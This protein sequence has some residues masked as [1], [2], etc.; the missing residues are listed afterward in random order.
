MLYP[1]KDY[2]SEQTQRALLNNSLTFKVG[3][4]V[5]AIGSS[6]L[7]VL[8]NATSAVAGDKYVI[9]VLVGFSKKNGEVI[10]YGTDPSQTPPQLTTS[11]TN[12]TSE[13]Y[14]GVFIPA[15]EDMEWIGDLSGAAGTTAYSDQP[16]AWFSLSDCRTIDETSAIA[17]DSA[18]APLQIFSLGTVPSVTGA[19]ATQIYFKFAKSQFDRP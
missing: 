6:N 10:S 4:A 19:A 5:A 15:T 16:Y 8:T 17:P 12:T 7:T 9:G 14:Y 18:S 2:Y 13:Q 1:A 11:A 3:D